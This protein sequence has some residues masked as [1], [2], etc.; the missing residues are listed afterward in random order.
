M[1]AVILAAGVGSRIRPLT[2]NKPKSLLPIGNDTI[3]GLMLKNLKS[4]TKE[5]GIVTGYRENQIKDYCASNFSDMMF[6]FIRNE[7]FEETNTGYSLM[8]AKDFVG[9]DSFLK[10]DADVV[11]DS[12]ILEKLIADKRENCLCIDKDINLEAEEIKVICDDEEK[13]LEIGKKLDPDKCKGESIGI[14]KIG[15]AAG[16]RLFKKLEELMQNKSNFNEYYDDQYGVLSAQGTPFYACDISGFNW[17]EIDTH[18][19]YRLA[20]ELFT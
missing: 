4:V 8:L 15:S 19:D 18:E 17:A 12:K 1:K 6:T 20:Q 16:E 3:L 10:F 9:G 5:V 13:V 2:D 14:E 7:V 11:F